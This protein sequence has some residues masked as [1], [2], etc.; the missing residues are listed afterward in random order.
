M[1]DDKNL[2]EAISALDEIC[3]KIRMLSEYCGELEDTLFDIQQR[4][5]LIANEE[6]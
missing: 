4:I 5:Y 3:G 1:K 6:G 2:L